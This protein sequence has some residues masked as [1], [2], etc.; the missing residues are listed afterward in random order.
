[1]RIKHGLVLAGLLILSPA[2]LRAED[3]K[4]ADAKP[5][6]AKAAEKPNKGQLAED[7]QKLSP[8][9]RQAK[10][11]EWREKHP[12]QQRDPEKMRADRQQLAKDLG[13][14]SEKMKDLPPEERVAKFREAV[15]K[16]TAELKE[17]KEKG[18]LTE[19]DKQLMERLE[20]MKNRLQGWRNRENGAG[21]GDAR[22]ARKPQIQ[23]KTT[24]KA[25]EKK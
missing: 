1:M 7:W 9:E 19:Q 3:T 23:P 25:D 17:K 11:K 21:P 15:E 2:V 16:K 14:D 24:E 10:I 6:D 5:A 20:Q 13:L 18:T 4:P 22:D 12:D 8:E